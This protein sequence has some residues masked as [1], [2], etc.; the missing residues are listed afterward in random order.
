M[1][2]PIRIFAGYDKRE[3]HGFHV[4]CASLLEHASVPVQITPLSGEQRKDGTTTFSYARFLVP[5]L[6][7]FRGSAIF[8]DGS[9]MLVR[10]DIAELARLFDPSFAVQVVKHDYRTQNP[11]KYIGSPMETNNPDYPRKN[12]SS[13]V[14]WNMQN[15]KNRALTPEYVASSTGAH[16]HRFQWLKDEQIGSLP[17]YWNFLVGEQHNDC[18]AK[19]AHFTLGI[20]H[21]AEYAGCDYADE[22]RAVF[23]GIEK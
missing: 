9:D 14:L 2:L 18:A 10:A 16:L 5:H 11:R 6:C 12:W 7:G 4:F 23:A 20:P 1:D 15:S 13:V 17:A 8:L 22:Y 3:K 21:F 19:I